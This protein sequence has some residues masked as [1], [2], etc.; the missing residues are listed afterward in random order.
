MLV[1]EGIRINNR[2]DPYINWE[3][4]VKGFFELSLSV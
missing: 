1:F 4:K 2:I 3:V